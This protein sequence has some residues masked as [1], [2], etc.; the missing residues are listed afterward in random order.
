MRVRGE[1][2]KQRQ[3]CNVAKDFHLTSKNRIPFVYLSVA[4]DVDGRLCE[5]PLFRSLN[6]KLFAT[7]LSPP[8]GRAVA[9]VSLATLYRPYHFGRR[10]Q[11]EVFFATWLAVRQ[12]IR[13]TVRPPP[14]T[15]RRI[16]RGVLFLAS[17]RFCPSSAVALMPFRTSRSHVIPATSALSSTSDSGGT[18]ESS[19]R[20]DGSATGGQP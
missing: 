14:K 10:L 5:A 11:P 12:T 9:D 20:E 4:C 19:S 18:S 17:D 16:S 1:K 2:Q 13:P 15:R 6:R 3:H 7:L 8:A